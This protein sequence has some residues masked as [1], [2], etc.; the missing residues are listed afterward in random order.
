MKAGGNRESAGWRTTGIRQRAGGRR[1][2][3]GRG[4]KI[5]FCAGVDRERFEGIISMEI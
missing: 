1:Y 4:A 2:A 3:W 5:Y